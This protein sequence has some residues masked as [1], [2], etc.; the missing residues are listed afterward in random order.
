MV[1]AYVSLLCARYYY[2][3]VEELRYSLHHLPN[4]TQRTEA[5]AR[6]NCALWLRSVCTEPSR[7][8]P[9]LWDNQGHFPLR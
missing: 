8:L 4:V 6:L 3:V 5:R 7:H 2:C 9:L 1:N